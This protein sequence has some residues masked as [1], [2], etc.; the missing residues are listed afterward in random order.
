MRAGRL[1]AALLLSATAARAGAP[2][3]SFDAAGANG[4]AYASNLEG[5]TTFD[6]DRYQVSA[7]VRTTRLGLE[8]PG[9]REEWSARLARELYFVTVAARLGTSPPDQQ[10]AR[11]HTAAGEAWFKF[12][13]WTLAPEHPELTPQIWESS[14]P[15]PNPASLDRTWITRIGGIYTNINAHVDTS[16]GLFRL[17]EG[18]WQI[19]V[20]ETY[21]ESTTFGVQISGSR[22]NRTVGAGA[23]RVLQSAIDYWGNYLPVSGWPNNWQ[24]LRVAQKFDALE[25][26]AAG[27]RLNMLNDDAV[28]MA[29]LEAAWTPRPGWTLKAGFERS[30]RDT[31]TPRSAAMAG[32]ARRW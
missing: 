27:T 18:A 13:G 25:L 12:Y 6:K 17:V 28:T 30:R 7:R 1:A 2:F 22:Y 10:S 11:F 15:A 32:L 3:V 4:A 14:G 23:P 21:R 31:G 20:S 26:T 8:S 24:S 19:S 5:G 16:A 9:M 29:A